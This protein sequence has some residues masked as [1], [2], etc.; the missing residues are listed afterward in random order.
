M[1]YQIDDAIALLS[2]TPQTLRTL[3]T[4]LPKGWITGNEGPDT[5]SP[6]DVIGHLI[7]GERTDW[8]QRAERILEH[9]EQLPFEPFDRFAQFRES[10]GQSLDELLAA[11]AQARSANL[12]ALR[13]MQLATEDLQKTGMHP[14]LGRVTLGQLL[15]TWVTHDLDHIVQVA[16]V[17]AKQ[18]TDA[19]GPWAKYLSVLH[20]RLPPT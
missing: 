16:R 1:D 7:H 17:M 3:L 9:G 13:R 4:G 10:Q 2:R 5:W 18:Y 20:D 8:I 14:A 11:F 6:Y 15:A 19:V 12:E